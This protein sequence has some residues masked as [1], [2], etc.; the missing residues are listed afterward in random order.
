M[1]ELSVRLPA[2]VQQTIRSLHPDLKRRVQ[3]AVELLRANPEAGKALKG[4]LDGWRSLRA[5]RMRIVYRASRASVDVA[6]IGPRASIYLETARRLRA[7]SREA[8]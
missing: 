7:L 5:G 6:A 3:S 4:A 8:R 2:E 1:P